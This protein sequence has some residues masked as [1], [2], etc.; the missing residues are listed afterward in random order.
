LSKNIRIRIYKTLIL[1]VVLHGYGTW[2]LALR[3]EHRQRVTENKVLRRI[4]GPKRDEVTN[5]FT[6]NSDKHN[7]NLRHIKNFYQ[8]PSHLTTYQNGV[9]YMGIKVYNSLPSYIKKELHNPRKFET[10]L[11]HFLYAHYFYSLK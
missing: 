10:C 5:H 3:E 8:P 1:P 11:K 9:Y 6:L 7:L 2:S 4:F